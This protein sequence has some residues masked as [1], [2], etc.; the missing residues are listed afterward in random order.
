MIRRPPRSTLFPYTTLFRSIG[1]VDDDVLAA[2][3]PLLKLDYAQ[4]NKTANA[5]AI[6]SS[7]IAFQAYLRLK[8]LSVVE[9]IATAVCRL[10]RYPATTTHPLL[11][12][13]PLLAWADAA[14]PPQPA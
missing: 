14:N 7:S 1:V 6:A 4:A 12:R 10:R 2:V 5:D 9:G 11:R 8:L 3:E 13:R